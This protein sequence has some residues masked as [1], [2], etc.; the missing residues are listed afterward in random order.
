MD[1]PNPPSIKS[2]RKLAWILS[3]VFL[4]A[5]IMGPGPGVYLIND[6]AASGGTILK[7]PA[8]YF[9]AVFWFAVEAAVIVA[10]YKLIW[11]D[12]SE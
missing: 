3:S 5:L 8:L 9:W 6:Y 2:S 12:E 1:G 11:K 4:C 7:V 10:A